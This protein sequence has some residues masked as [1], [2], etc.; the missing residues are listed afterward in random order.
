MPERV[1]PTPSYRDL[2]TAILVEMHSGHRDISPGPTPLVIG[3]GAK[4]ARRP[5]RGDTVRF[6]FVDVS[7]EK[8]SGV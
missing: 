2:V 4:S 8:G 6:K 1:F 3:I 5:S 7:D